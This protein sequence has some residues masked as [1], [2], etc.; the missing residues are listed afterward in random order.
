MIF[1][2]IFLQLASHLVHTWHKT[3]SDKILFSLIFAFLPFS[4]TRWS[5]DLL[6][7]YDLSFHWLRW[8]P[9]SSPGMLVKLL[10]FSFLLL[11]SSP[12]VFAAALQ[13]IINTI[14]VINVDNN[15]ISTYLVDKNKV[16]KISLLYKI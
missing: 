2:L 11:Y 10:V 7:P 13:A 6:Y 16:N 9:G 14:N 8:W 15:R 1:F 4:A 12:L 5:C 3:F